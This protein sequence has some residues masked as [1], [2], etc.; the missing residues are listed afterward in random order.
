MTPLKWSSCITGILW[1]TPLSRPG[2]K[3]KYYYNKLSEN[4]LEDFFVKI[5]LKYFVKI[6]EIIF[7]SESGDERTNQPQDV[8]QDN[9]H[10]F[11]DSQPR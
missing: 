2:T 11:C 10:S 3:G 9:V 4:V 7:P 8:C 6:L 1:Q 5:F